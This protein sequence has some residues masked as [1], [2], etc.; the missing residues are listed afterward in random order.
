MKSYELLELIGEA[1]E[2]SVLAA[3]EG[4][5][6]RPRARWTGWAACAACAALVL[7]GWQGWRMTQM[8]GTAEAYS[9]TCD[10]AQEVTEQ[11][12]AD[13]DEGL[14][15][16]LEPAPAAVL[17]QRPGLHDYVLIE[18]AGG[19]VQVTAGGQ[20]RN[21][22]ADG[23]AEEP[24]LSAGLPADGADV[25]GPAYNTEDAP[26]EAGV[27]EPAA[28]PAELPIIDQQG[29]I[30]QYWNLLQHGGI[31][32]AEGDYPA[33]F[34]G[35]WLDNDWPDNVSRLTVAVTE[36][37]CTEALT[38]KIQEWC[39]GTGDVQI[40]MVK[41]SL[42]YLEDVKDEVCAL[43]DQY[44]WLPSVIDANEVI[45]RVE[46]TLFGMPS[47][48]VLAALAA[49]DPEGDAIYIEVVTDGSIQLTNDTAEGKIPGF[50]DR[51]QAG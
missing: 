18:G 33:W 30:Q 51:P 5:A 21:S 50:L 17:V 47:D 45:G 8:S 38:A 29:A 16:A 2:Q 14:S 22:G 10:D 26:V 28:A 34:G 41:Y 12:S 39:G 43:F 15:A 19:G 42:A 46:V 4:P 20:N 36:D 23:A 32:E 40:C 49:L 35:V 11:E 24:V 44:G 7:F 48:D 25:Y 3:D 6:Q 27:P 37:S 9:Q 31:N 13:A 1:D